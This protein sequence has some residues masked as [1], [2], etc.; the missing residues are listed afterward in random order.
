[1]KTI[2]KYI[3]VILLFTPGIRANAIGLDFS[4][5]QTTNNATLYWLQYTNG[6]VIRY[7][8]YWTALTNADTGTNWVT[9]TNWNMFADLPPDTTNTSLALVPSNSWVVLVV[10]VPGGLYTAP[11][12]SNGAPYKYYNPTPGNVLMTNEPPFPGP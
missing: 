4:A 9:T 8:A 6:P 3:L 10:T 12:Y 7:D 5:P 11:Y 1:M 2:I